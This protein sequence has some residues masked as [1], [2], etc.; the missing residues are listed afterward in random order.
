MSN[1]W[2]SGASHAG[3]SSQLTAAMG[4][5]GIQGLQGIQGLLAGLGAQGGVSAV[6]GAQGLLGRGVGL[7]LSALLGGS[8]AGLEAL[9]LR[10]V[11]AQQQQQQHVAAQHALEEQQLRENEEEARR[12]AEAA[13]QPIE[14]DQEEQQQLSDERCGTVCGQWQRGHCFRETKCKFAHPAIEKGV[15]Q[16]RGPADIIR[17]NFKTGL[18]RMF[19]QTSS[20]P[21]KDRCTF[22]H[23]ASDLRS[24]KA[25]LS[26]DQEETVKKLAAI[27]MGRAASAANAQ[28]PGG[29]LVAPPQNQAQ[30][31]ASS[32]ASFPWG[33]Q[34]PAAAQLPNSLGS[35]PPAVDISQLASVAATASPL[36]PDASR[37]AASLALLGTIGKRPLDVA[38]QQQAQQAQVQQQQQQLQQP[39]LLPQQPQPQPPTGAVPQLSTT[40]LSLLAMAEIDSSKRARTA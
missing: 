14:D 19:M 4:P 15:L 7:D 23:G 40:A 33:A 24:S 17:H 34:V 32:W 27:K 12:L 10:L 28:S 6:S 31:P 18:C 38:G 25:R 9:Q 2:A 29:T 39:W 21:Q 5:P 35:F 8:G 3:S 1:S 20:C 26:K 16:K 36:A 37:L 11:Q 13:Q 22:A 30:Q